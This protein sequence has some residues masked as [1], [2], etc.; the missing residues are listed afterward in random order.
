M[1]ESGQ[2]Q[3]THTYTHTEREGGGREKRLCLLCY[4]R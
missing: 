4:L 2:Y 3:T 1:D